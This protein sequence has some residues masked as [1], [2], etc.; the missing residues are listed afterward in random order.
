[1][2]EEEIGDEEDELPSLPP[3]ERE[4]LARRIRETVGEAEW[5]ALVR[6]SWLSR[7]LVTAGGGMFAFG[8][9]FLAKLVF[10]GA[11]LALLD[12]LARLLGSPGDSELAPLIWHQFLFCLGLLLAGAPLFL[13]LGPRV[14]LAALRRLQDHAH[15]FDPELALYALP[16]HLRRRKEEPPLTPGPELANW[17]RLRTVLSFLSLVCLAAVIFLAVMSWGL[18]HPDQDTAR[19]LTNDLDPDNIGGKMLLLALAALLPIAAALGLVNWHLRR[20][21]RPPDQSSF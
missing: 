15:G 7:G 9:I 14:A 18:K 1:M 21:T 17:V 5:R 12:A 19:A 8:I 2:A 11:I 10:G 4:A 16:P 3:E 6:L 13:L 20:A